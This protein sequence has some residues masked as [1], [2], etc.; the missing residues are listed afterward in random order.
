MSEQTSTTPKELTCEQVREL[1]SD[2]VDRELTADER[3]SVEH[4]LGTCLKCANESHNIHGLKRVA[5]E[6]QGVQGS[7]EFRK[8]VMQRMIRE[9]QQMPAATFRQAADA[10]AAE[11]ARTFTADDVESK[12]VP[13][14]WILLASSAMAACVYFLIRWLRGM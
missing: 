13:P 12:G 6:W 9:S 14:I 7:G 2:Y 11:S 4:H 8:S 5:Q 10:A 1:L 3:A